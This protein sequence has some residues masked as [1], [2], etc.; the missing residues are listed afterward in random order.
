MKSK[1]QNLKSKINP[2]SQVQIAGICYLN[3]S[4]FWILDFGLIL[5]FDI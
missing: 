2:K 5:D 3:F 4:K 1:I